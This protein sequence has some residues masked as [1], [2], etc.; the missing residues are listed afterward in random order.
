MES[1]SGRKEPGG[2]GKAGGD[3]G[4]GFV[5]LAQK[6]SQYTD[7]PQLMKEKTYAVRFRS[8]EGGDVV[9]PSAF[10]RTSR[11]GQK[12]SLYQTIYSAQCGGVLR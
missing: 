1:V 5:K 10:T 4:E 8:P 9:A 11:G 12:I 7:A 2:E 6:R 3:A